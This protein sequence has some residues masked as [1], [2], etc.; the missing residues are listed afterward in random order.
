[1]EDLHHVGGT[2]AGY[3]LVYHWRSATGAT[4]F[5]NEDDVHS[6]DGSETG[7]LR[8]GDEIGVADNFADL[9]LRFVEQLSDGTYLAIE[10]GTA[11]SVGPEGLTAAFNAH[12]LSCR[13]PPAW[14]PGEYWWC[15]ADV[16]GD[17]CSSGRNQLSLLRR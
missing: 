10:G 8:N 1:M 14:A 15:G 17:E 2:P 9:A 3:Q 5:L 7:P 13:N 16:Q 4:Q 12:F 6:T 11:T